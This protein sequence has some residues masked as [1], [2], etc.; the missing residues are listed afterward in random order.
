MKT[1]III[2]FN[3]FAITSLYSQ[4]ITPELLGFEHHQLDSDQLGQV[5][6]YLSKDSANIQKP[7]LVYLDG[8]G[9]FPLFQKLQAGIGS[10]IV[11]DFQ[12]LRND[13]KILLISKPGVPFI[14]E[15]ES[16]KNGFP[17][18]KEPEEYIET[19]QQA[20]I[21]LLPYMP[22][23]YSFGASGIFTEAAAMGKVIV[24]TANTTMETTVNQYDLAA[25]IAP[26]YSLNS[27]I[28]ALKT[29]INNFY[30]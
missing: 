27:Y 17:Q 30:M 15:V 18:Y 10:T 20:D 9:A 8:S 2:L 3:L 24:V 22:A 11:I 26:E 25:I 12:R 28:N 14:D 21:V 4:N 7:L 23:Y 1:I 13:Y 16:D 5:N 29:S 19:M 6:Y